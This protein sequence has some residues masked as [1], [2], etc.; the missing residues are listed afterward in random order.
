MPTIKTATSS[1]ENTAMPSVRFTGGA[2]ADMFGAAEA[3]QIGQLGNALGN[4]AEVVIK[5]NAE[6]E[7]Q[8]IIAS[9]RDGYNSAAAEARAFASTVYS[10]KGKDA[11]TAG[12]EMTKGLDE[13]RKRYEGNFKSQEEKNAFTAMFDS[14]RNL[15]MNKA[16]AHQDNQ[17]AEWN[18]ASQVA[19]QTGLME[20]AQQYFND[21]KVVGEKESLFKQTVDKE[22]ADAGMDD[23]QKKQLMERRVDEFH[24]GIMNRIAQDSTIE[25]LKYM[26]ENKDKFD[27]QTFVEKRATV[28]KSAKGEQALTTALQ[29]SKSGMP[30]ED[31]LAEVD[32]IKDPN[33]AA[34]TRKLVV[35]RH[36]ENKKIE[37]AKDEAYVDS[38]VNKLIQNPQ[39]YRLPPFAPEKL[40]TF[41]ATHRKK[42]IDEATGKYAQESV[43]TDWKLYHD[44]G[45]SIKNGENPDLLKYRDNFKNEDFKALM[46]MKL[47]MQKPEGQKK[48]NALFTRHEIVSKALSSLPENQFDPKKGPDN[49]TRYNRLTT[50]LMYALDKIPDEKFTPELVDNTV[51]G[52]M[53]KVIVGHNW[54]GDKKVYQFEVGYQSDSER[55]IAQKEAAKANLPPILRNLPL[56]EQADGKGWYRDQ[57][58]YRIFYDENG[59]QQG[60]MRM[61]QNGQSATVT[62]A[63]N[64]K[65]MIISGE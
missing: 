30:I 10:K 21:P 47:A 51:K 2:N 25:A 49:A 52:L 19:L 59:N 32:K 44:L 33:V 14:D 40:A 41:V 20:D 28:E 63:G 54:Y 61:L 5:K 18:K 46:S 39:G 12:E 13:I 42:L 9:S 6:A 38:E 56:K 35:E 4:V 50:Q 64:D 31:Q 22:A 55:A 8:K 11:A 43:N 57:G 62:G 53:N 60:K 24:T 27:R 48:A 45:M 65:T 34:A 37:K 7:R 29:L 26:D 36:E 17:V 15:H 1:V 16:Y 58:G 3:R 23:A